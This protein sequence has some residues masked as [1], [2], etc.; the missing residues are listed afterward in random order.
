MSPEFSGVDEMIDV[1][2]RP[3]TSKDAAAAAAAVSSPLDIEAH[4]L[5]VH[6]KR[7]AIST[8]ALGFTDTSSQLN[9]IF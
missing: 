1:A 4:V 2:D 5:P 3:P 9:Q 7:C 6:L 8:S